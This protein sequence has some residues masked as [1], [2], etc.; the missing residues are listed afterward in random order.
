MTGA[1]SMRR[2]PRAAEAH[3]F[4]YLLRSRSLRFAIN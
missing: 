1:E 3:F 4:G 2:T